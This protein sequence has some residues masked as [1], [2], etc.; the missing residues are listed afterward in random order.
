MAWF[1][2]VGPPRTPSAI[3]EK[4]AAGVA[5]TLRNPEV[6]KRLSDLSADPLGLS[7]KETAAFM[8]QETERWGS[9][10]RCPRRVSS[11]AAWRS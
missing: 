4:V 9:V 2:I 10:I 3:A 1:G 11:T 5:E 7:P 8:K 6:L